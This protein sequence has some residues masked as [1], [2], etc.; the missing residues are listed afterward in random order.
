MID[1]WVLVDL[2]PDVVKVVHFFLNSSE[3]N[4]LGG[5]VSCV[6]LSLAS[7]LQPPCVVGSEHQPQI[8]EGGTVRCWD[9]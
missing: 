7:F 1:S 5:S 2:A 9:L 4:V 3:T 6:A 8:P